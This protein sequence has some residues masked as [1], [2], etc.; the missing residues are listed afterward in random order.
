MR[1][2]HRGVAEQPRHRDVLDPA[3]RPDRE[4][5]RREQAIDQRKHE[6]GIRRALGAQ[7][8]HVLRLIVWQG[9]TLTLIGVGL[10]LATAFA[11]TRLLASLLYEVS[12]TDPVTFA[13]A[14]LLLAGMAL[15]AGFVPAQRATRTP[16]AR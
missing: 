12:A 8:R 9:M 15:V 1:L 13:A 2:R 6:I 5:Q 4:R 16:A 11:L 10:G 7:S 14:A 3:E